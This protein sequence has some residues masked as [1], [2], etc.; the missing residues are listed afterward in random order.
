[1]DAGFDL[2][3]SMT[4]ANGVKQLTG[5]T[6]IAY[7]GERSL[8]TLSGNIFLNEQ[9]NAPRTA[10]GAYARLSAPDRWCLV[11]RCSG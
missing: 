8:V 1:M 6:D 4:K 10:L 2:G 5:A 7:T 11:C 3:Y 9:A